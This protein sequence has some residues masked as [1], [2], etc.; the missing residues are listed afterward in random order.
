MKR[1][2]STIL[3]TLLILAVCATALYAGLS[4]GAGGAVEAHGVDDSS[5]AVPGEV[6]VKFR[7]GV[8]E[9]ALEVL[10]A[11]VGAAGTESLM[12]SGLVKLTVEGLSLAAALEALRSSGLVKYAEPNYVRHSTDYFPNDLNYPE[13]WNFNDPVNDSDINMP[14]AWD[15]EKGDNGVVVAILDTGVAYRTGGRY[16]QATDLVN[17]SFVQGYDFVNGDKYADDDEG[18][19]THVCGTVAQSTDNGFGVTGVAFNCSIMPVK[20]LDNEGSGSDDQIIEGIIY[21]ADNGADVINMSLSG[22]DPS[23]ALEEAVDY[24][25]SKGVVVCASSGNEDRDSVGYPAASPNS[26]AVGATTR[27]K[28]RASYSNYGSALDV[29]AP[30]GGPAGRIT[31]E[32]F[33]ITGDPGSGFKLVSLEGTSMACP[34]VAGVAALVKSYRP[35]WSAAEVRAAV[36]STCRDLGATGW[37]PDYGWG[38]ID[39]EAALGAAKPAL[40]ALVISG[41]SP[42]YSKMGTTPDVMITGTKFTD[43]VKVL[44]EREGEDSVAGTAV[45]TSGSTKVEG[46]IDLTGAQP[47]PWDVT[48][49]SSELVS[50]RYEGGFMVDTDANRTWYLAEG[51]TAYGFEEYVLIQNPGDTQANCEITFMTP[52][53]ALEP[54]PVAV[55]PDSRVTVTVNDIVPDTD[56]STEITADQ[57]IICERSMYWRDRVEGTDCIGVQSPSYTWYLAEGTTDYGFDTFLLIQNPSTRTAVVNVTYMTP[58]GPVEKSPINIP[59]NSRHTINVKDDLPNEEMSFE[60]V[61]NRRVIAERS[62]YWDG[63]RGGHDSIGTN[64]PARDWYLGEGSTD[65]GYDEYILLENPGDVAASV[66]ITYMTPEGPEPQPAV[67]VPPG[68]RVTVHVNDD[69]PG[70]DVSAMVTADRGIVVERSMYWNNGT[71]KGGHC[72]IATPQPRQECFLAEGSTDWG[73]DEWILVQNPNDTV[74]NV[75]IEYMTSAGLMGRDGFTL[76]AGSRVSIRVNADIPAIDTSAYVFSNLPIIAERSMYWNSRGAGHVSQG[77]MR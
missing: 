18:H 21:A 62:M 13:Q 36:T 5:K 70:R 12:I 3:A 41:V 39:A 16:T 76:E 17:T 61:S 55:A 60:V 24:A 53:G 43:P 44:L 66:D 49:E 4:P 30:G 1:E 46:D 19:G 23:E 68:S 8:P 47:G 59:A 27:S 73:F 72:A 33:K 29:V 26:I 58:G 48:V 65:W 69:L 9:E 31:Q 56:V 34:H 25:F 10:K 77:L 40:E 42:D 32:T 52:D 64:S 2:Y 6:L 50:G 15:I 45:T 22:P 20:V 38:L 75:G 74:A 7:E 71:G 14:A 37:D 28:K 54:H 67:S 57:D 63:M 35:A 11:A 51:S